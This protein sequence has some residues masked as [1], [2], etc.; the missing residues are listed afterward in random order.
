MTGRRAT[1]TEAG[2]LALIGSWSLSRVVTDRLT[3]SSGA[4]DGVLQ[5]RQDGS[6]LSWE[7]TGRL[8]VGRHHGSFSR[9]YRLAGTA[10]GWWVQFA[11]GRPFHPWVL[12]EELRHD[13]RADRYIGRIQLAEVDR[14]LVMTT[15]WAV[16]G[17]HKDQRISTVFR[18]MAARRGR[19]SARS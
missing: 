16:T 11:D 2:P 15:D 12:G 10:E 6:G 19:L 5:I 17:P 1:A 14:R 3:P 9:T 18:R 7:E 13:C 8:R 4:A